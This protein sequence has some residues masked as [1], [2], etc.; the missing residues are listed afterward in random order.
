MHQDLFAREH[1]IPGVVRK[2]GEV[3]GGGNNL[4]RR[5]RSCPAATSRGESSSVNTCLLFQIEIVEFYL[6][7]ILHSW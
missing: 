6:V 7:F 4:R 2:T 3:P 1:S 5:R